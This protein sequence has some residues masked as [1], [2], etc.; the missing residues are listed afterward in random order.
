MLFMFNYYLATKVDPR[1]KILIQFCQ[2]IPYH[3]SLKSMCAHYNFLIALVV[4]TVKGANRVHY[5]L[6][7]SIIQSF[8]LTFIH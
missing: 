7:V 6:P 5:S 1:I 3:I 2:G 8:Q 4:R